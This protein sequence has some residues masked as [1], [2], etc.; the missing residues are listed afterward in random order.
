MTCLL[1][2]ASMVGCNGKTTGETKEDNMI[3]DYTASSEGLFIPCENGCYI[4]LGNDGPVVMFPKD[5]DYSI[6]PE[7]SVG[8]KIR[9]IH[10]EILETYPG[11]TK[12]YSVEK[13]SDGTVH[14]ISAETISGLEELGWVLSSDVA[15]EDNQ[16]TAETDLS[17]NNVSTN[18]TMSAVTE[19]C[20]SKT[21]SFVMQN[22]SEKAYTYGPEYTLEE[23]IDNEWVEIALDVPLTW[24][25]VAF[26]LESQTTTEFVVDWTIGYGELKTG[27]YRLR[28]QVI[29]ADGKADSVY[30]EFT[31]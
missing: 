27:S 25:A 6:F 7:L 12:V 13:I 29:D 15:D 28:K 2:A 19:S 1:L 3:V 17:D 5:N 14:D 30:A 16:D 23:Q 11:R 24:N 31:I 21:T 26:S 8:D 10:G 4:Y 18:V 9:V 22:N 20:N